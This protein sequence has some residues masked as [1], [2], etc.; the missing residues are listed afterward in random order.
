MDAPPYIE[1]S[2]DL[3]IAGADFGAIND[4][5]TLKGADDIARLAS[6]MAPKRSEFDAGELLDAA[7]D[8]QTEAKSKEFVRRF[9]ILDKMSE[10]TLR[11]L[12]QELELPEPYTEASEMLLHDPVKGPVLGMFIM[13]GS[14]KA[15]IEESIES[16]RGPQTGE[17]LA[18]TAEKI[19][20]RVQ[21][22]ILEAES[23]A[24]RPRPASPYTLEDVL[25]F[26]ANDSETPWETLDAAFKDF[27]LITSPPLKIKE[28][29]LE[30]NE[31]KSRLSTFMDS[32]KQSSNIHLYEKSIIKAM[33]KEI[34][35]LENAENFRLGFA[36]AKKAPRFL[37]EAAKEDYAG[38]S[39]E[40]IQGRHTLFLHLSD[41]DFFDFWKK[42]KA[43]YRAIYPNL[44]T[45]RISK[46]SKNRSS[47]FRG[48]EKRECKKWHVHI[49][50]LTAVIAAGISPPSF[51]DYI[52]LVDYY[53]SHHSGLKDK[54]AKNDA[55]F[56]LRTLG[57]AVFSND[58][59]ANVTEILRTWKY[60][61]FLNKPREEQQIAKS[62]MNASDR[63]AVKRGTLPDCLRKFRAVTE[64]TVSDCLVLLKTA[65]G[66]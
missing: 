33:K 15:A 16:N 22:G 29:E 2:F 60:R 7:I 19:A 53:I 17:S 32:I 3:V 23:R 45:Q 13:R 37:Q 66:R 21:Q 48:L 49:R 42:Y 14:Q 51:D 56:F 44:A 35:R 10:T 40:T 26:M 24:K 38:F 12:A 62:K 65:L 57:K 41:F 30:I 20:N 61:Y 5:L 11:R 9:Q 63:D 1:P 6:L 25:R 46:S 28:L 39:R 47:G 18:Q 43:S 52:P 31:Y 27:L 54:D 55:E 34:R 59:S 64:E 36:P 58:N 50:K 8:L 4:Y